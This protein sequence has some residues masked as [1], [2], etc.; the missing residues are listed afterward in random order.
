MKINDI[1]ANIVGPYGLASSNKYQMS[2]NPKSNTLKVALTNYGVGGVY[3]GVNDPIVYEKDARTIDGKLSYLCDECNI[4]GYS[5][6]TG[7]FKGATPGINV[8]YAHT[9]VYNELSLTFLMDMNHLPYKVLQN[10]SDAIYQRKSISNDANERSF[11]QVEYYDYYTADIIIE[12]IEPNNIMPNEYRNALSSYQTHK[13][14][15]KVKLVN[16]FPYTMSNI[17]MSNGPNQPLKFQASFYYEYLVQHQP[18]S[19]TPKPKILPS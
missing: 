6:A 12:K 17:S 16:A 14:V 7:E 11:Y 18:T 4:P 5:F 13:S 19:P 1:M 3:Q 8:R 9:K 2:I 10:W 15:T